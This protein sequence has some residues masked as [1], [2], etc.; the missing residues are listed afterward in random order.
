MNPTAHSAPIA[1]RGLGQQMGRHSRELEPK[2]TTAQCC[3]PPFRKADGVLLPLWKRSELLHAGG[4]LRLLVISQ[5]GPIAFTDGPICRSR[6]G[7]RAA[8]HAFA[9]QEF[10]YCRLVLG[11]MAHRWISS[12]ARLL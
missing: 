11:A 2:G 12:W 8:D 1:I 10:R 9:T 5:C 7:C 6:A 4:F 3:G